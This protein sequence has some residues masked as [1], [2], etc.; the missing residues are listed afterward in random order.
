MSDIK[1][2]TIAIPDSSLDVVRQKLAAASFPDELDD[3]AWAY[4]TPLAEIKRLVEY[5]REQYDWR[6]DERRLNQ[7]LPQFTTGIPIDGFGELD[8]H[9]VHH[10]SE[11]ADA[12][13]LLFV[14]GWP[15]T[16]HEVEKL[17]PL[18]NRPGAGTE[19]PAFH[20]IA[21]SLPNFGFSQGVKKKGFIVPHY[22]ETCHK[23]MLKLGYDE[24]VTQAGDWGWWITRT[25]GRL[26]PNSCKASH[27]NMIVPCEPSIS[28]TPLLAL[29]H[30]VTPYTAKERAGLARSEW[31]VKEGFG[32]NA[33]QGTKP[34]SL[35]YGLSDSPVAL[36]AWIYEK[37][38]DWTDAYAFADDEILAWV[39]LYLFSRAGPVASTRIYYEAVHEPGQDSYHR[40]MRHIPRVKI[41]LAQFP[42]D[43]YVFPRLWTRGLGDVVL[44]R[45][46]ESGGHFAAFERP[47]DLVGDLC[48]MFGRRGGAYAVVKGKSGFVE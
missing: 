18:L 7:L 43:I 9:F 32:Y 48:E 37:L 12:V 46:H 36:L 22:A 4:G 10:R 1:A 39:S 35:G 38:H 20:I 14:H 34:Q 2:F 16:F 25:M 42:R 21:P 33:I 6:R 24:Y 31:F 11:V 29:Q 27:F 13:P 47:A 19:R 5:W 30:A 17:I 45:E 40:A 15:G 26:Y 44:Y 3:A 8:I 23:L 41:G 28:N